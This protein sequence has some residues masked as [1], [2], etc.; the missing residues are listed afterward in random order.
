VLHHAVL[1]HQV[2]RARC[3]VWR[4]PFELSMQ[5]HPPVITL[6]D[7]RVRRDPLPSELRPKPRAGIERPQ[8][9]QGLAPHRPGPIRRP[10]HRVIVHDDNLAV[11]AHVDIQLEMATSHLQRQIKGR[12]RIF[13]GIR[14]G[15]PMGNDHEVCRRHP[16]HSHASIRYMF[17]RGKDSNRTAVPQTNAF[18]RAMRLG[19]VDEATI[20]PQPNRCCDQGSDLLCST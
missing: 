8:L 20:G 13:R 9:R 2:R 19:S 6:Q 15:A 10:V 16:S 12:H 4:T 14:G 11:A 3:Q 7:F 17:P 18:S 1:P 5:V